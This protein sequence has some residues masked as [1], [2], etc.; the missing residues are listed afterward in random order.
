MYEIIVTD[1]PGVMLFHGVVEWDMMFCILTGCSAMG[2][3]Y[4]EANSEELKPVIFH[5]GPDIK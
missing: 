4:E 5:G 3:G 2:L 1:G